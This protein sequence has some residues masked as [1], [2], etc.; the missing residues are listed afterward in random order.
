MGFIPTPSAPASGERPTSSRKHERSA[1][2]ERPAPRRSIV[3]DQDTGNYSVPS[4][5]PL[6]EHELADLR[7]RVNALELSINNLTRMLAVERGYAAPFKG[8]SL[9]DN[10]VPMAAA[11]RKANRQVQEQA[12][13]PAAVVSQPGNEAEVLLL[14]APDP[15]HRPSV[16]TRRGN[17]EPSRVG[18]EDSIASAANDDDIHPPEVVARL[19]NKLDPDE[20]SDLAMQFDMD[21]VEASEILTREWKR[22]DDHCRKAHR[23]SRGD[24]Q[25]KRYYA[26]EGI[27]ERLV[28]EYHK[29]KNTK[30]SAWDRKIQARSPDYQYRA[31]M[32]KGMFY[33]SKSDR[34]PLV[35]GEAEYRRKAF[36]HAHA[37]RSRP[38][39]KHH[40]V[41]L[42]KVEAEYYR[43]TLPT[44][45]A[46]VEAF[47]TWAFA[48][49]NSVRKGLGMKPKLRQSVLRQKYEVGSSLTHSER[50]PG[51][52]RTPL[53]YSQAVKDSMSQAEL[54]RRYQQAGIGH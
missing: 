8:D 45:G 9:P 19:G 33:R 5:S 7:L 43:P 29:S 1:K 10:V 54:V 41:R 52:P 42:S 49:W 16:P 28:D 32:T 17:Y 31:A 46:Q 44:S 35:K 26:Q 15:D 4:P 3:K 51:R 30:F 53:E 20:L 11:V 14:P 12:G 37:S 6:P 47:K 2:E 40:F 34:A 27:V 50:T 48:A 22:R 23:M 39:V 13:V 24:L 25:L 18:I 38:V 21:L 36:L